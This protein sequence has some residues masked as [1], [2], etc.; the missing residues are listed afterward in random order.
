MQ[1][2]GVL[3]H[4]V[5]SKSGEPQMREFQTL[6]YS[7]DLVDLSEIKEL[8]KLFEEHELVYCEEV[9][10]VRAREDG[11]MNLPAPQTTLASPF[12]KELVHATARLASSVASAFRG[13]LEIIDS[14]IKAD[15]EFV[16][17]RH[18]NAIEQIESSYQAEKEAA[19]DNFGLKDAHKQLELAEARYNAFYDKYKRPPVIYI[20]HWLYVILAITIFAGEVPLNALVFQIFGE[21]Q[22]MTWIMAVVVGLAVPLSAHF[23]GIK[24][25]EHADGFSWA[26]AIKGAI[27]LAVIASALYGLARM[28]QTYLGEFKE[29][30]GLTD[31]LVSSSFMFFWLNLAVLAA[32]TF[33]SYLSHD[34][35]P[36]Y[37]LAEKQLK[38]ARNKLVEGKESRRIGSLKKA[39]GH[40]QKAKDKTHEEFRDG[41]NRVHLLK[42]SY[43]QLLKEGQEFE[44]RCLDLVNKLVSIYRHEN[45]KSRTDK[46]VP[47]SFDIDVSFELEL[48]KLKEKLNNDE[49]EF[50]PG[51]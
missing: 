50:H 22:V 29:S 20:P 15:H 33:I 36:G 40:R 6:G 8:D 9:I 2:S 12:E 51:A 31:A 16:G 42:G 10:R 48:V 23:I 35:V 44:S 46:E 34:S 5:S 32:A 24:F 19:E 45:L 7:F 4:A 27:C 26:N 1:R 43:D 30:L 37:E 11:S 28:R 41:M 18:T 49:S 25:R 3:R 39:A 38:E 47:R 14:K 21:N 17:S 13:P